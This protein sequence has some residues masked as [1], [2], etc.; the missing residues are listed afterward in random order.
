MM[1][2]ETLAIL[3][4]EGAVARAGTAAAAVDVVVVSVAPVVATGSVAPVVAAASVAPVVVAASVVPVS[5][6]KSRVAKQELTSVAV[7]SSL[8]Q[9][10]SVAASDC[11]TRFGRNAEIWVMRPVS[12][13]IPS[14]A[15][16]MS[17]HMHG[18]T[19]NIVSKSRHCKAAHVGSSVSPQHRELT[20][21]VSSVVFAINGKMRPKFCMTHC[22]NSPCAARGMLINAAAAV[23]RRREGLSCMVDRN[24]MRSNNKRS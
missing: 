3:P 4:L 23:D 13:F 20:A 11:G 7:V 2:R 18:S 10:A 14:N 5:V 22:K 16:V 1:G 24:I 8:A 9:Q 17:L 6:V 12:A 19:I 21:P 15:P